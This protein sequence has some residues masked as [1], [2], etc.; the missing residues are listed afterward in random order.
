MLADDEFCSGDEAGNEDD[1]AAFST[2]KV[3]R[4]RPADIFKTLVS[5][6]SKVATMSATTHKKLVSNLPGASPRLISGGSIAPASKCNHTQ[7][8]SAAPAKI[9]TCKVRLCL[10]L[11][12][13]CMAA[14]SFM[15]V[16]GFLHAMPET[17]VPDVVRLDNGAVSISLGVFLGWA[18]PV[19]LILVLVYAIQKMGTEAVG[20][21]QKPAKGAGPAVPLDLEMGQTKASLSDAEESSP[22]SPKKAGEVDDEDFVSCDS[23]DSG[24]EA[25]LPAGTC[26]VLGYIIERQRLPE[27]AGG[28]YHSLAKS[29]HKRCSLVGEISHDEALR[30]ALGLNFSESEAIKKWAEVCGW[31]DKHRMD[32]ENSRCVQLQLQSSRDALSFSH[33]DEIYKNAFAV[34]PCS[35][36]SLAG[37]PISVWHV[38]T[39]SS[40]A[41]SVPLEHIEEWGRSFFE[42][43]D[44]FAKAQ[45][46]GSGRLLGHIQVFDMAGVGF[47]QVTNTAL[48]ERIKGALGCGGNYVE[49]VS[50]IYVINAS[51][52]FSKIWNVVKP[53]LSPRT[54]SKVTVVSDVP[55][56]LV[57]ILTAESAKK[58]PE[59]LKTSGKASAKI[60]R[61]PGHSDNRV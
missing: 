16:L 5:T 45:S 42:Y 50:H 30:L 2:P 47:R 23:D 56:A 26:S 57:D 14:W 28:D 36:I 51:W 15:H 4:K 11:G 48:H 43:V 59:I 20:T 38:G 12:T 61:P 32:E 44:V 58:L 8:I 19:L 22:G 24:N 34:S 6:R 3:L 21:K 18:M 13:C 60:L 17:R 9:R 29:I 46:L 49:L 54:A 35:L 25:V 33:Q 10:A 55:A 39:G 52:T 1:Q 41:S 27:I 53:L 7:N 40:S 31:R 37:E